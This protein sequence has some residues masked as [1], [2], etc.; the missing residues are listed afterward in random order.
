MIYDIEKGQKIP[1]INYRSR[2]KYPFEKMNIGDSFF[3]PL[4][5]LSHSKDPLNVVSGAASA[6]G[7]RKGKKFTTRTMKDN[8][9]VAVGF[10]VWRID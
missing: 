7:R 9:N 4:G 2:R 10:R 1:N 8:D 6:Y 5:D 3:V